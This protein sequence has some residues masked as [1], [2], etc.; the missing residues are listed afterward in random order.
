MLHMV[1]WTTRLNT[2][3]PCTTAYLRSPLEFPI[4]I[5]NVKK[6][7]PE[8][9]IFV[10]YPTLPVVFLIF[11]GLFSLTYPLSALLSYL[12]FLCITCCLLPPLPECN[13]HKG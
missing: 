11:T 4:D 12:I 7:S 3:L 10:P 2:A 13:I 6:S 9:L 8:F 1:A 5:L